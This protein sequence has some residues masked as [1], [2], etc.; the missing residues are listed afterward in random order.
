MILLPLGTPP[1][2]WRHDLS[3]VLWLWGPVAHL[4]HS[5]E[6]PHLFTLEGRRLGVL[7]LFASGFSVLLGIRYRG[8]G[9]NEIGHS[10]L[11]SKSPACLPT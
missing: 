5:Y 10:F 2:I 8:R 9:L 4:L 3:G 11:C 1:K 7:V 6:Q